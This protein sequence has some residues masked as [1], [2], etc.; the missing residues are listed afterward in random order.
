MIQVTGNIWNYECDWRIIT[1]NG[2]IKNNG[3]AVLGAGVAQQASRRYPTLNKDLGY[4]LKVFGNNIYSFPEFKL[5]TF[6][7]KH[8]WYEYA[9]ISLVFR[10]TLQLKSW[11][12]EYPYKIYVMPQAGCGNGKLSWIDVEP[13]LSLLPDNVRVIKWPNK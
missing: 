2:T 4:K 10:S 6:P 9:D 7:V 8:V 13:I 1:T 12:D 5:I 11:V 3:E